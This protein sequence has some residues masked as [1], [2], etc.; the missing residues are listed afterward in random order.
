MTV[1][2]SN[3]YLGMSKH[4]VVLET[5]RNTLSTYGAGAGGT[6]NIAG[7]GGLH[8]SLES[9]LA[10]LHRKEAA[11]VFSSCYVANDATLATLG[12]KLP[13]CV[14]FSDSSNHAS[15]IQGI[16]HSGA[17]KVIFKHNDMA[18][19]EAKL[20]AFPKDQPKIIAFESVYSMC[21]SVGPIEKLCDLAE[22][23][24][25]ITFL[26]EVHA[27]GMY[28]PRGAGVAEHCDFEVQARGGAKGTVMDRIDIIT[29][30]LGKAYGVVGGYIAAS[31][32]LVDTVR[33]YAPGFIFTT[34]LPPAVVAGAHAAVKYQSGY[35]G[36]RRLQQLNTIDLK[37]A[38]KG[39]DMPVI[40]GPSHIVPI[41]VGDAEKAKMASDLL[42]AKHGIYV[43][44]VPMP[45]GSSVPKLNR[46][47][48][49][50]GPS[51]S[52][53]WLVARNASA[54]PPRP[55]TRSNSRRPSWPRSSRSGSSSASSARP[56]GPSLAA[57][58]ALVSLAT[59][60]SR[61]NAS[62]P[63]LSSDSETAPPPFASERPRC[64]TR[65][66][67]SPLPTARSAPTSCPP[68]PE[69]A[70][71]RRIEKFCRQFPRTGERLLRVKDCDAMR[72]TSGVFSLLCERLIRPRDVLSQVP[73]PAGG[74]A[75][76]PR[77]AGV[78]G[79]LD[80]AR[81]VAVERLQDRLGDVDRAERRNEERE[82][83][84]LDC[85]RGSDDRCTSVVGKDKTTDRRRTKG[86]G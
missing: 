18:D 64:L 60:S 43:Q 21:G 72:A 7:N 65:S 51:I 8:L 15:M 41:L 42:L 37:D 52:Q 32:S 1:W 12:S 59:S 69:Q 20:R 70:P 30:T 57:A 11:L 77:E 16:R 34:S 86:S 66:A 22:E 5:M 4:P 44:C 47:A 80:D 62:G 26:D 49:S 79:H 58:P 17:Q 24:G 84:S 55:V 28:G 46:P 9:S 67:I 63:T 76:E 78:Q 33:S 13:N 50:S 27:I 74:P 35:M 31:A 83:L 6:R 71:S 36:D 40:P 53:P 56:T 29:A 45:V 85:R 68:S 14:I 25:A 2:C 73:E 23:Y 10:S 3:D 81:L 82:W 54:S 19:L 48:H 75:Q 39:M 38:L 61:R